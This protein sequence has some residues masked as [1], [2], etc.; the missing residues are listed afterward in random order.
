L[1]VAHRAV[2][3]AA[4]AVWRRR[5]AF[6][7]SDLVRFG[8]T[9]RWW[10]NRL[11]SSI[12]SDARCHDQLLA[13]A[14]PQVANDLAASAGTREVAFATVVSVD[15]I[16]LDIE[17]R[18]I[19][20]GDRIVLLDVDDEPCVEDGPV[21]VDTSLKGSFKIDGMSIGF[22]DRE[23]IAASNPPNIL[24]WSPKTAPVL[25]PG[26]QLVVAHFAWF[27]TNSGNRY[28]NVARPSPDEVSAPKA[29]CTPESYQDAPQQHLFC[30]RPHEV[31]EAE[32]S[33]ELAARRARGEL[34]PEKWPPV[35]DGDA[36]EVAAIG[37]PVGD[38]DSVPAEPV[39]AELTIDDLE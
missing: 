20:D 6:H 14:N 7:A 22:L 2:E 39:P 31:V 26:G 38:P 5:L 23:G 8:R 32:F 35:R 21:V 15:P 16:V 17:S 10:R 11:V 19:G 33:D 18:R 34:N 37:A 13:L 25:E 24:R 36:F 29:T 9:Y 3:G 12:E 27:S 4:Q 30:C 28:V 1:R